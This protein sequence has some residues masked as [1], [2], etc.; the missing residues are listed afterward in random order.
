MVGSAAGVGSIKA[1]VGAMGARVIPEG[2]GGVA[3]RRLRARAERYA[4]SFC[5]TAPPFCYEGGSDQKVKLTEA[6]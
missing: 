6:P 5:E 3:E 2:S 4:V 1:R